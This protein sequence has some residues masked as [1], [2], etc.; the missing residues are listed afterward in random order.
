MIKM[1]MFEFTVYHGLGAYILNS[2]NA[3]FY[4]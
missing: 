4:S 3:Q 1:S 2:L